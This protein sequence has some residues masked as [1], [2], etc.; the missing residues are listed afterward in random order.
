L[1]SKAN[2]QSLS[3]NVFLVL[4]EIESLNSVDY[5]GFNIRQG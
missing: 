1:P 5:L 4:I 3:L 2:P